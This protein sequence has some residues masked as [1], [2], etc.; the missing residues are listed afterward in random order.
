VENA[1]NLYDVFDVTDSAEHRRLREGVADDAIEIAHAVSAQTAGELTGLTVKW[2]EDHAG[3]YG[4]MGVS[5]FSPEGGC[6]ELFV[7]RVKS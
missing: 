4:E 1:M 5:C 3:K 7:R 2:V 6:Q